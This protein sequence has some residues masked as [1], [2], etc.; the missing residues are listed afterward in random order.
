MSLN[1]S[2]GEYG[3]LSEDN[4]TKDTKSRRGSKTEEELNL[5]ASQCDEDDECFTLTKPLKPVDQSR[6]YCLMRWEE[7]KPC[8]SLKFDM[9]DERTRHYFQS[10]I[11]KHYSRLVSVIK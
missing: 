10:V 4:T 2:T 6:R 3:Y 9:G 7:K 5:L 1:I 8:L 11:L